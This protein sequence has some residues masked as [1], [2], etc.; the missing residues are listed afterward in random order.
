MDKSILKNTILD[1]YPLYT[2]KEILK[3]AV[4]VGY[5]IDYKKKLMDNIH[6]SRF[7]MIQV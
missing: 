3:Q 5:I 7:W 6:C 2:R 4:D 1:I